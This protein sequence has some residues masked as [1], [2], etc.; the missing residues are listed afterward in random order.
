[1]MRG[2]KMAISDNNQLTR[3][4]GKWKFFTYN[5]PISIGVFEGTLAVSKEFHSV[6]KDTNN[7]L[8]NIPS[9]NVAFVINLNLV[10][11]YTIED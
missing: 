10:K 1:M 2:E 11:E 3:G 6:Y 7:F 5:P 9:Q 8:F 4:Y